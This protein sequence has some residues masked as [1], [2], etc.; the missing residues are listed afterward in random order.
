MS[1]DFDKQLDLLEAYYGFKEN[2]LDDRIRLDSNGSTL[3]YPNGQLPFISNNFLQQRPL[4]CEYYYQPLLRRILNEQILSVEQLVDLMTLD[5][6]T[7][8][9]AN[10]FMI[11]ADIVNG[12][13]L[14]IIN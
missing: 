11:A 3:I 6:T 4:L 10:Q 12:A 9:S 5:Y 8:T 14:V 13:L 7:D 1:V 2:L